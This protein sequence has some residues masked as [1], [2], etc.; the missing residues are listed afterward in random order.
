MKKIIKERIRSIAVGS[1]IGFSIGNL[2]PRCISL[3]ENQRKK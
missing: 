1:L 3:Y 2:I